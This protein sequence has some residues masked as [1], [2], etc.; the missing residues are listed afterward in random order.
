MTARR[1][2]VVSAEALIVAR[3][4]RNQSASPSSGWRAI[5][6]AWVLCVAVICPP[7]GVRPPAMGGGAGG[8][9]TVEAR[10]DRAQVVAAVGCSASRML[11]L[12][13]IGPQRKPVVCGWGVSGLAGS[14]PSKAAMLYSGGAR[15]FGASGWK[16]DARY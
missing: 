9:T 13:V 16:S 5:G 15:S 3:M 4:P 11:R 7:L 8:E 14:A 2:P 12:S 10:T 6:T 1:P